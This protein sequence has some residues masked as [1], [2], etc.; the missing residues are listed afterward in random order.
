[1]NKKNKRAIPFCLATLIALP[2][3]T[4]CDNQS[5]IIV[6]DNNQQDSDTTTSIEDVKEQYLAVN[7]NTCIGCGRCVKTDSEHFV[8]DSSIKKATV[9]S[10][11]NLTTENLKNA[12]DGCPVDAITL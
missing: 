2:T 6:Q 9:I 12:I 5:E 11:N 10:Q 8:L 4:G 7:Q 3:F 1:M